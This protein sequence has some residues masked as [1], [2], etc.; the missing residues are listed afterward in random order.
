MGE[1]IN[2]NT[3]IKGGRMYARAPMRVSFGG[4]N[5]DVE[6]YRSDCGGNT[7]GMAI[8]KYAYASIAE[9]G[10]TE[11]PLV[12]AI[13]NKLGY[14]DKLEVNSEAKPFSG[15][16]ASGAMAIAAIRLIT[17]GRMDRKKMAHLAFEVEREDLGV[18]GGF[19]DQVFAAFG[20][21][22]YLEFGKDRFS[23]LPM[24][25]NGFSKRLEDSCLL[26]YL[27]PRQDNMM[28]HE[29]EAQR[30]K[31]NTDTLDTIKEIGNDMR[32]YAR[33]GNF[34]EFANL[35][36]FAW[37]EKRRLSPLVSTPDI[38]EY[39]SEVMRH[40]ALG[41]K[42]CGAGGG[43]HMILLCK[44]PGKVWSIS[45]KMGYHP[46]TVKIDWEGVKVYK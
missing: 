21:F 37:F 41:G 32:Y 11:S 26:V 46:E 2:S 14:Y 42:L 4:G 31:E 1:T 39:Y 25:E 30:T 5:T 16:G 18:K 9:N 44:D 33:R 15:L 7:L 13:R 36:H 24:T 6:P 22:Q 20:G 23:I 28:I 45:E 43:G 10:N 38:D 19:Q 35:L 17:N 12:T 27:G 34:D 3:K 8:N 40:G 29:D